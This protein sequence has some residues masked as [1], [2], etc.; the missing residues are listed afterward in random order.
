MADQSQAGNGSG[1][2]ESSESSSKIPTPPLPP[3]PSYSAWRTYA[4]LYLP[5][6]TVFV[7]LTIGTLFDANFL[8]ALLSAIPTYWLG[9]FVYPADRAEPT[10]EQAIRFTRKNDLYRAAVMVTYRWLFGNSFDLKI[11]IADLSMSYGLGSLIGERPT[12]TKQRRSEFGVAL[13][14]MA[15]STVLMQYAPSALQHWVILADRAIWRA[16]YIALV[17]DV[18]GV[19]ARP[20]VKTWKGKITLVLTQAFTIAFFSWMMLSWLGKVSL[21][22]GMGDEYKAALAVMEDR[23]DSVESAGDIEDDGDRF[24]V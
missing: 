8:W 11:I 19:L 3:V 7:L 20:N 15:G 13:L 21:A 23:L 12:G 2:I 16:T 4:H 9:S 14:W 17:D 10:P 18:V 1:A 22:S 6:I 24:L 5:L